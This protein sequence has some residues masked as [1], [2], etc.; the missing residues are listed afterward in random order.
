MVK[1][2]KHGSRPGTAVYRRECSRC[3]CVY[4]FR[5]KEVEREFRN[6][7]NGVN[8]WYIPCPECRDASAFEEPKPVRY[9]KD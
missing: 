4:E 3:G 8:Y 6:P 1:I 9:E 2:V 5:G 7:Q